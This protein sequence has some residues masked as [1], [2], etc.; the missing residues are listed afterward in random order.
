[1]DGFRRILERGVPRGTLLAAISTL[2]NSITHHGI[3]IFLII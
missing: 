2:V 1:V 3:T